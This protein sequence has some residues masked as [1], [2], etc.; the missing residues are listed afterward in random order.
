MLEEGLPQQFLR[1]S[2]MVRVVLGLSLVAG[3]FWL[4]M[5]DPQFA[6]AQKGGN[7][8]TVSRVDAKTGIIAIKMLVATTKKKKELTDKE[9]VLNDDAKVTI[10]DGGDK[11]EMTG[12]EAL[13]SGAIKEGAS[14]TFTPEGDLKIKELIIGA[15]G[16]KK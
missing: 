10:N 5:S 14:V 3:F 15:G 6:S 16:K 4:L 9:W 1:S 7:S 8:G 11:K 13:A 12:K 2:I